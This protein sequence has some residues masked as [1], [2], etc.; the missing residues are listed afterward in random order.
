LKLIKNKR[1]RI[2]REEDKETSE[3]LLL[4]DDDDDAG[5]SECESHV[6]VLLSLCVSMWGT[7]RMKSFSLFSWRKKSLMSSG[8]KLP[9][10]MMQEVVVVSEV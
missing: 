7:T 10:A 2:N 4:P 8:V 6:C 5:G 9:H 1:A 3:W